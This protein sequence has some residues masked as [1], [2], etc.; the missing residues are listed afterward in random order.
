[1]CNRALLG[2]AQSP[3]F[4]E[5]WKGEWILKRMSRIDIEKTAAVRPQLLDGNLRSDWPD[6][7][8]LFGDR[9]RH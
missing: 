8:D 5:N 4:P 6:R 9:F 3:A 7:D 1:M 2:S